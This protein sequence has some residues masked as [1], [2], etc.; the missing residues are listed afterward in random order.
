MRSTTLFYFWF[1][2][3]LFP[4]EGAEPTS[5]RKVSG[6]ILAAKIHL[7]EEKLFWEKE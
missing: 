6:F 4:D 1:C 7:P 2:F 5:H 3:V